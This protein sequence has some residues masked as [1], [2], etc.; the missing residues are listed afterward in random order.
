MRAARNKTQ[1]WPSDIQAALSKLQ[2]VVERAAK[3]AAKLKKKYPSP[4]IDRA[5]KAIPGCSDEPG[6]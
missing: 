4:K 1:V 5:R 3:P 6:A 2:S